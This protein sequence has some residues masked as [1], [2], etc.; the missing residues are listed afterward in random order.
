MIASSQS[1][2]AGQTAP[3]SSWERARAVVEVVGI[4]AIT[5]GT[6]WLVSRFPGWRSWEQ[7]VFGGQWVVQILAFMVLP[8]LTARALVRRPAS[9]NLGPDRLRRSFEAGLTAL[10]IAGPASGIAFPVLGILGWS[11]YSWRGGILLA[12]VYLACVPLTGLAL[13]K[14]GPEEGRAMRAPVVVV[15]FAAV[16]AAGLVAAALTA[17]AAPVVSRVLLALLV[18][19]PGEEL[20]FRGIVQTRLDLALGRP[21]RIWGAELGWGWIA[22]S[23]LFGMAHLLSPAAPWQGGWALWT[24]AAGLLFGYIRAKSGSFVASALVH[25]VLLAVAAVFT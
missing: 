6:L 22:A 13:R 4:V 24:F 1:A 8:P 15:V 16:L 9:L 7:R 12:A 10:A 3:G 14:L 23:F 25:G 11:P 17:D 19:G 21:W 2:T 18:V 20:L 5:L